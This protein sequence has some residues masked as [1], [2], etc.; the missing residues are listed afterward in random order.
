MF[1]LWYNR[2]HSEW[3]EESIEVEIVKVENALQELRGEK[4][5]E[6]GLRKHRVQEWFLFLIS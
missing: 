6:N 3:I 2:G 5:K 1:S 4:R